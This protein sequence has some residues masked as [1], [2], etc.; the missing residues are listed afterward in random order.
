MSG[1]DCGEQR[2]NDYLRKYAL[3]NHQNRS[4]RTYVAL[5]GERVVGF[6]TVAAGS[7]GREETPRPVAEGLEKYPVPVILLARLAVDVSEQGLGL[8]GELLKDA[9]LRA[10][11]A[12]DI[13]GVRAL[14][15]HAKDEAARRFYMH[16]GFEP[17]PVN[18]LHLYLLM[19]DILKTVNG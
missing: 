16:F 10:A 13:I 4:A 18:S 1:F 8:G 11:H 6:Y 7:V 12:A 15:T 2:L 14:L 3:V 9:I 5:R 19:K 17:S